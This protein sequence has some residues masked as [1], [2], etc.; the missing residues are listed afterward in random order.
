MELTTTQ[1]EARMAGQ[2][3]FLLGA[4]GTGKTTALQQRLIRLLAMGEPAYTILVMVA[5]PDHADP[6]LDTVHQSGLGPYADLKITTY[7]QMAQEMVELFWPLVA[8]PS[9]FTTPYRPP[10]FLSY[11][12]AQLLMWH[13]ITPMLHEGAFADLRLR[14]QQIVSQLLDT[15]NRAALNGLSLEE[16]IERQKRTWTGEPERLL[17]LDD[18]AKAARTFRQSCRD[19]GLL[20]LSL[21]V[22]V[23]DTQ[24]VHHEVF[25]NYFRERY[26]HLIV[27]NVE[28]QTP[29]GQNFVSEL[30]DV[31]QT[32]AVAYD[33]GGGYKRFLAADPDGAR[34]FYHRS[35]Y[36]FQFDDSFTTTPALEN[37]ANLVENALL[38]TSKPT[39]MA[40]EAIQGV[41]YGRYRREMVQNLA[42]F[43][44]ELMAER[45]LV[46]SDIA[47]ITPYL[48][49]AL[50]YLLG[51]ALKEAGLPYRELRRRSSPRDEPR[52]RAWLTWLA[53][54]HPHWN[55][56]P[57]AYDVAEAL[58]LSI[59]GFDPARAELLTERLYRPDVP[60][61][62]PIS[63]L[64]PRLVERIGFDLV[65]LV[66]ELR[67]WLEAVDANQLLDHCLHDLFQ[68]LSQKRFQPEPDV[69]GAAVCDWLVRAATRLRQSAE[70]IGFKTPAEIG[71]AFI[72]G[73]N[74]GL[75]TANPPDLGDPPDPDG[76]TVSTIYGYLLA[77]SP[78]RVQVWLET[79][80]T[81]WWDIPNQ[82]L[83]NAFVLA[84]S[85][86]VSW[87][88]T[89]EED[90][91]IRN[92]LLARLIRGLT[93]RC[94]A[95]VVLATSDLDRRGVRQDGPLWRALQPIR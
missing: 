77:G 20:D 33:G 72:D 68:L 46:P 32:T 63:E 86:D 12:L 7:T 48:D 4:A 73:I 79:A 55:V 85:Y 35:V 50:R 70:A 81:G 40:K 3:S 91:Q 66:E 14:P 60:D 23:F 19:N 27:D 42:R 93:A 83:S 92:E 5:E 17:H 39:A 6:Y 71:A 54:A 84:Q 49:G 59:H 52:V 94:A 67:L 26:R 47:I 11:D 10:T 16:A 61:L 24:L 78:A 25:K 21:A 30:M 74:N 18:A 1:Q 45:G 36:Q 57:S 76:I 69:A 41:V 62:L 44:P 38:F 80:A 8:R 95:G 37:M 13:V 88:W 64:P 65:G 43:L 29:A 9:G 58:T 89:V 82:P 31:T 34:Q 90:Y 53:L 87:P 22:R 56:H 51:N 15:L 28:E 75:V 2:T